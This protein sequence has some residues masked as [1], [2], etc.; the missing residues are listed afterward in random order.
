MTTRFA[1]LVKSGLTEAV[2][3]NYGAYR[4]RVDVAEVVG[5]DIDR[6]LFLFRQLPESPHNDTLQSEFVAVVGPPQF[7]DFPVDS[8]DPDMG[9]PYFRQSFVELD[10]ASTEQVDQ[11]WA[12]LQREVEVFLRAMDRLDH[13]QPL[14]EVWLPE[15]PG[16]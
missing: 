13:L 3:A 1:R 14:A 7:A 2:F 11:I 8:P 5:P 10:L 4:L 12:E 16:T 9:W 15:N 6:N